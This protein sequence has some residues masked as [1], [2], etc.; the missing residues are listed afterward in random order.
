MTILET[1]ERFHNS[2]SQKLRETWNMQGW[3][4]WRRRLQLKDYQIRATRAFIEYAANHCEDGDFYSFHGGFQHGEREGLR[5]A[6]KILDA[7]YGWGE[8]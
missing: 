4:R 3:Q 1:A 2:I 8:K 7:V 5:Y 6:L